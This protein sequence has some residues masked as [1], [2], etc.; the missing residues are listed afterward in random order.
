LGLAYALSGRSAE[1]L[2][3]LE[4]VQIR[5]ETLAAMGGNSTMLRLGE[6]YLSVGHLN[7]AF[8]LVER[9]QRL[10]HGR[11]ERGNLAWARWLLGEIAT[12]R[13]PPELEQAET[14]YRE[15]LALA[16]DLGMRPLQAHGHLGLGTLYAKTGQQA[17]ARIEL[18]AAIDLYQAMDMTFWLPLAE[19]AL[20]LTDGPGL[21]GSRKG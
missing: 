15:A 21:A 14:H 20:A 5:E 1:A 17:K 12:H 3:L 2:P 4:Q 19:A 18:T 10:S 11:K 7:D 9:A 13:E 8:Q 6:A 16:E